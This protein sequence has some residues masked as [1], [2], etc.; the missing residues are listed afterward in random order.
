MSRLQAGIGCL[1]LDGGVLIEWFRSRYAALV[2]P[3]PATGFQ[4]HFQ[5]SDRD[6]SA[7]ERVLKQYPGKIYMSAYAIAEVQRHVRDGERV[8]GPR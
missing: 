7:W 5:H 8:D 6:L 3:W 1:V 4:P 2:R